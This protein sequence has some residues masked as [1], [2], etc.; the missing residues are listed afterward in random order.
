MT[1]QKRTRRLLRAYVWMGAGV[2]CAVDGV[3]VFTEVPRPMMI[4]RTDG[5]MQTVQG[6]ET[7]AEEGG[8]TSAKQRCENDG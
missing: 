8:E 2:R 6:E 5:F 4:T 7:A 3:E 1:G